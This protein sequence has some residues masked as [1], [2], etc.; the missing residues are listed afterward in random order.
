M[1][2]KISASI[3]ISGDSLDFG[4][5]S[6]ALGVQPSSV[7]E[8]PYDYDS[9]MVGARQWSLATEKSELE[10]VDDAIDGLL[11]LIPSVSKVSE[12]LEDGGYDLEIACSVDVYEDRPLYELS[13]ETI[14]KLFCLKA[15]FSMDIHDFTED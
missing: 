5:C 9:A 7:F 12:F 15:R 4:Q 13:K 6:K 2:S 1:S 14:E 3:T 8:R 10:S 11:K